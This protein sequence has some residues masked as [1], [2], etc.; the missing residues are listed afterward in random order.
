MK[1]KMRKLKSNSKE[2]R[3]DKTIISANSDYIFTLETRE[4][5]LQE[6]LARSIRQR[7]RS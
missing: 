5:R 2:R 3:T 1:N 7:S 4:E 6:I